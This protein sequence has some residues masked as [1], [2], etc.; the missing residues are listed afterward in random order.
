[1][2]T[3]VASKQSENKAREHVWGWPWVIPLMP[4]VWLYW[5]VRST[6]R[7]FIGG[8]LKWMWDEFICFFFLTIDYVAGVPKIVYFIT[9]GPMVHFHP[10]TWG[11]FILAAIQ[12]Y[13][14]AEQQWVGI[15]M[16][17]LLL[18]SGITIYFNAPFKAFMKLLGFVFILIP[19][20][21]YGL[22]M[23][24]TK[25]DEWLSGHNVWRLVSW[26]ERGFL[27]PIYDEIAELDTGIAS[28]TLV[29]MGTLFSLIVGYDIF[30]SLLDNRWGF[31]GERLYRW[32][33]G[34]TEESFATYYEDTQLVIPDIFEAAFGFAAMV[35]GIAAG[36]RRVTTLKNI[37]F[38]A[39]P[40]RRAL[41]QRIIAGKQIEPGAQE[42]N[43]ATPEGDARPL[44]RTAHQ[45]LGDGDGGLGDGGGM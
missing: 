26:F 7:F 18:Y 28:G 13:S 4:F 21:D 22:A 8:G 33:F 6:V 17:L 39:L 15:V 27:R 37:P 44:V 1:M 12:S 10:L 36:N 23:S 19:L 34:E 29:L 35:F 14:G 5:A 30:K 16:I 3:E 42:A 45:E 20:A 40:G 24:S 32:K 9:T 2:S 11:L 43:A 38:L 31:D 25:L 41:I